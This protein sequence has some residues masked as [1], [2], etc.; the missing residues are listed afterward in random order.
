[1]PI[2]TQGILIVSMLVAMAIPTVFIGVRESTKLLRQGIVAD[3]SSIFEHDR[4]HGAAAIPSF[5]FV[6][7]KYLV[8]AH[9]RTRDGRVYGDFLLRHW[10][11]GGIPL[12]LCLFVLNVFCLSTVLHT[13]FKLAVPIGVPWFE[14]G[15]AVPLFAWVLLSSYVGGLLFM[16]RAFK[17]A[18][19]NFDMSPL[20]LVGAIVNLA[21]GAA[22]GLLFAFAAFHLSA[23]VPGVAPSGVALF[24]ILI[25]TSFAAGFYPDV[26]VRQLVGLSRLRAYKR[27]EVGFYAKFK[28]VPID[29]VDGIDA[30]IRSRLSDYHIDS[31]QNLAAANPLMLF[32]ETPYGVYQIMD[33]VAQAQLCTSVGPAGLLKLWRLGIRTIF[34]LERLTLDPCCFDASLIVEVGDILW[35][36]DGHRR[37]ASGNAVAAAGQA[38]A[39]P[40]Y[41]SL[42][43][44][45]ADIRMRLENPHTLRL[46]QIFN[47]VSHSL[48]D[49]AR[50]LPPVIC[51]GDVSHPCPFVR[52]TPATP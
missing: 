5:E 24:P 51:Y 34:D 2:V 32:V 18:V 9:H 7:Y 11:L 44:I 29:V 42:T 33:W 30:E 38:Q 50:R 43:T 20:S 49:G 27:E 15:I 16:L 13:A 40:P 28:A 19:N 46:R 10:L 37:A 39:Q 36:S 17:Q 22:A 52:F 1:M 35:E 14:D 3:L 12:S 26:A 8:D 45:R 47:Q 23:L 41:P 25:V 48:G 4:E 6:K 31:V 21:F